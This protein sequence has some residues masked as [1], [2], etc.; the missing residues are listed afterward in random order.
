M[1]ASRILD[2]QDMERSRRPNEL[3]AWVTAKCEELGATPE[4]KAF[5]R[6]GALVT[7]KFYEEVRPLAIFANR[8]FAGRNDVLVQPNLDNDNFDAHIT[9]GNSRTIFVEITYAKDGY[10]ESRRMEVLSREGSVCLTGSISSSG[11]RGLTNRKVHVESEARSHNVALEEHIAMVK[12]RLEEKA[13]SRY[14]KDHV[15]VV[16]VDDYLPLWESSDFEH[17]CAAAELWFPRLGLDFGRV[18]FLGVAGRH[19]M[20]FDLAGHVNPGLRSNQQHD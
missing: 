1:D 17:L 15:L 4:A 9:V 19:Y 2:R 18:V 6:S 12:K 5:A 8:E 16:A 10:D 11:R 14:G 7:K 3:L 20:S 13:R